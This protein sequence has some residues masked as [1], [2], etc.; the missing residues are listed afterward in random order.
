MHREE[1]TEVVQ[2][3]DKDASRTLPFGSFLG[4]LNWKEAP[5]RPRT[6]L[7]GL[8]IQYHL[9]WE[10]LLLG[11][12]VAGE[13]ILWNGLLGWLPLQPDP[14]EVEESRIKP[15]LLKKTT[16]FNLL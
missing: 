8:H 7:G 4:T 11:G 15:M 2:E 5:A 14:G 12:N 9:V 10:H 1:P 13:N 3:S 6:S 16:F